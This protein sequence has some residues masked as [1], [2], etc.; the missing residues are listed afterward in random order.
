[1]IEMP[2]TDQKVLFFCPRTFDYEKEIIQDLKIMG[3][4]VTYCSDRPSEHPWVKG[5]IRLFPKQAW[6]YCDRVYSHWL[7]KNGPQN[8]NVIFIIR[9]EGLSPLFIRKLRNRY[10]KARI[11]LHLWDNISNI[12]KV[13]LKFPYVDEI[14]SYDPNDCK[15][16]NEF[17]F[18]P[19]FF[20]D[21]YLQS[22][23]VN[24]KKMLFIGTLHSDRARVLYKITNSLPPSV[25]LDYWLLIRSRLEYLFRRMCDP[26]LRKLDRSRLIF[27]P[28]RFETIAQK[29]EECS[30][31]VDIEHPN[32]SGLTM[33]TFE[34]L[35]AGKK[36]ITTNPFITQHDFYDATRIHVIDRNN[37]VISASFFES[38]SLAPS[39]SFIRQYA[40]NG[41]L[42]DIFGL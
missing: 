5:F 28:M 37:P 2:L 6:Y 22:S 17:K 26:Y 29:Y 20:I 8:C 3:A 18:R 40:L 16:F 39:E 15:K 4:D 32:N 21:K 33:R 12:K 9:G 11:L 34:T 25:E 38:Q 27:K 42:R 13:E 24:N 30:I 14:T 41:W 35:A 36:L 1:M 31:V 7:E 23:I 10:P 19:L